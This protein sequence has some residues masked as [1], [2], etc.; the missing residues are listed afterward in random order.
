[1]FND[2]ESNQILNWDENSSQNFLS[3]HTKL[4]IQ[5]SFFAFI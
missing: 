2:F 1:M 4:F 3:I 5:S